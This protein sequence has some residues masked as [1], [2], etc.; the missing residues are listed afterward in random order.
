MKER[1]LG[2]VVSGDKVIFVDAE[3]GDASEPLTLQSDQT[4]S[5]QRGERPEALAVI[6]QQ[7]SNY[8]REN[9]IKRTI[10]KESAV[11][12]KQTATKALLE[13][14]ELRG[15]VIA[16]SAAVTTTQVKSK[17]TISR[18]FGDRKVD[19]YLKDD[20]FWAKEI[21]GVK[22]RNGSREAA[23]MLIDARKDQ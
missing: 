9:G 16:A 6:S 18:T 21:Q 13:S 3:V 23:M 7:F 4:L 11:A 14:A 17:A 19:E 20:G 10:V 5:L 22:L 2:V 8:I 15:V 12:Q 1:W